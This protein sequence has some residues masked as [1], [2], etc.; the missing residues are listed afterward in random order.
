MAETIYDILV[1][2]GGP[3]GYVAAIR[4]AQ[5]GFKTAVVEREH[6]GGICLNWGCIPTKALLRSAEVY[7][8]AKEGERFGVSPGALSADVRAHRRAFARGGHA[9]QRRRRLPAQEEQDRRHLGRGDDRR[10]GRGRVGAPTK[11]PMLPQLPS[12]KT[13]LGHGVYQAK[14]I[15]VATGARPRVLPGLEPDGKLIWTYFEAMKPSAFRN[16]CSSSAPAPSASNSPPSIGRSAS[17]SLSSKLLP[18]ILPSRRRRDRG[19]RASIIQ[20]AG[21]RHPRRDDGDER[22][23]EGR[24]PRRHAET[25]R[26]RDGDARSR[27]RS[28]GDRRRR[29]C[30]KSRPGGARRRD[31]SGASSRSTASAAPMS[32]AFTRSAMSPAARCS[33]I[34]PSMRASSA[35]RRSPD[36]TRTRSTNRACRAAPIVTRRSRQRRLDRGEGEGAGDRRQDRPLP[37]SRQWQGDRARRTR[38]AW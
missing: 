16:R 34:R 2:G 15:I 31:S 27:A 4:A 14:H 9:A 17:R 23:E 7:H 38:R 20:E 26:R 19:S 30:R 22:R 37:L 33:R 28:V 12:P 35:S 32:K 36:W 11:P 24:Q 29:Q 21:D 13:T 25:R 1:I 8:L 18:H 5:L 3:G 6:L 10:K